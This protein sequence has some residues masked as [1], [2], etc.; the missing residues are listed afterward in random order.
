[1][2]ILQRL[3]LS[4]GISVLLLVLGFFLGSLGALSLSRW[5]IRRRGSRN[6]KLGR[7]AEKRAAKI[8]KSQG[9]EILDF[10]P[11]FACRLLV[12]GKPVNFQITPDLLVALDGEWFVVEV[13]RYN[14]DSAITNAGVRRQVLEYLY[15]TGLRCLLVH[16]PEGQV[17]LVDIPDEE[18]PT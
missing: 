11:V 17:D 15:A 7:R 13:K 3:D 6:L 10:N 18:H 12:N 8:L 16:M 5:L 2:D 1:M 9:Y 4:L 14:G